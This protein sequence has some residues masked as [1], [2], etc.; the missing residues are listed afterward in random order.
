MMAG[1]LYRKEAAMPNPHPSSETCVMFSRRKIARLSLIA[2]GFS[3]LCIAAFIAA[4]AGPGDDKGGMLLI[5]SIL[6]L[7][8]SLAVQVPL[9]FRWMKADSDPGLVFT[10]EGLIYNSSHKRRFIK[11]TD[12]IALDVLIVSG[13]RVLVVK[14]S[15]PRDYLQDVDGKKSGIRVGELQAY[16]SPIVFRDSELD[17]DFDDLIVLVMKYQRRYGTKPVARPGPPRTYVEAAT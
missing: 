6:G 12:V 8:L 9:L 11:W 1:E 3:L 5:G 13:V 2:L 16:G 7:L 14:V 17:I 4:I 15:N 10:K